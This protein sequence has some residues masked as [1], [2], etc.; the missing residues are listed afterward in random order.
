MVL[1]GAWTSQGLKVQIH[2]PVALDTCLHGGAQ[3]QEPSLGSWLLAAPRP[4]A[5]CP[6]SPSGAESGSWPPAPHELAH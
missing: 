1:E 3:A 2:I 6:G 5:V 4:E